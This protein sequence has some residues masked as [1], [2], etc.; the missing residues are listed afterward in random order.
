M[1]TLSVITIPLG[2]DSTARRNFCS[3]DLSAVRS[4]LSL[5][6]ADADKRDGYRT[7]RFESQPAETSAPSVNLADRAGKIS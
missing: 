4:P 7:L 1:P 6:N 2:Q 5:I 3:A